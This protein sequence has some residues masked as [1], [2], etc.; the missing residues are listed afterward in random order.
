MNDT[1]KPKSFIAS[2]LLRTK[3]VRII[4]RK[5]IRECA[6][7]LQDGTIINFRP[8]SD[9]MTVIREIFFQQIYDRFF[10][11]GVGDVVFDV[12]ANIGCYSL[13]S[14]KAV[15][16]TGRVFA[17][18]PNSASFEL[19]S[20]NVRVNHANNVAPFRLALGRFASTASLNIY[21]KA[22]NSSFYR[23]DQEAGLK[24]IG[25]ESVQVKT[26]DE[27]ASQHKIDNLRVLK[28]DTEGYELEVLKGATKTLSS[29]HPRIALETHKNG[30]SGEE[31]RLFLQG[32][33]YTRIE[34][35][36]YDVAV[37]LLFAWQ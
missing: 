5:L 11:P 14:S 25:V 20:K 24:Q 7:E 29:N 34:V 17:F 30:A 6:T 27:I 37:G 12:G 18:E 16:K 36:P 1:I 21:N 22:G 33:G 35:I 26:L 19:L 4:G 31:I 3:Y 28:I 15:G 10:S 2:T 8:S 23:K 9:D 13:Q 32:F